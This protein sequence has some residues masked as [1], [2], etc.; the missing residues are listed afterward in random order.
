MYQINT[1]KEYLNPYRHGVLIANYVEDI[2]GLDLI[3]SYRNFKIDNKQY[4]SETREKFCNPKY[5][6][7]KNV[8]EESNR[9]PN[10]DLNI[11]FNKKTMSDINDQIKQNIINRDNRIKLI[12]KN[13]EIEDKSKLLDLSSKDS[14][15]EDF[16][17]NAKRNNT[18]SNY[19]D[20]SSEVQ[21]QVGKQVEGFA[22]KDLVGLYFT[23]RSG[24]ANNLL[25]GHGPF[26]NKWSKTEHV[27]V[28]E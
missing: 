27:S 26:Q 28:K 25:R 1:K 11:D 9:K 22:K 12:N 17:I 6:I 23:T 13:S 20:Y 5:I 19:S 24:L 15:L 2:Y 4:V 8:K 3:N 14:K 10:F 18:L 16:L 7:N 21:N